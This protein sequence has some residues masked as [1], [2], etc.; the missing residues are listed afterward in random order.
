MADSSWLN[1]RGLAAV[2]DEHIGLG[3][4]PGEEGEVRGGVVG[5]PEMHGDEHPAADRLQELSGSSV[6]ICAPSFSSAIR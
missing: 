1:L 5:L 3:M 6:V 2:G 4:L